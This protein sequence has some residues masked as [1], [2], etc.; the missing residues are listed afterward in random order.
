MSF[1]DNTNRS[2]AFME[3]LVDCNM[4]S[5]QLVFPFLREGESLAMLPIGNKPKS[6]YLRFLIYKTI[7]QF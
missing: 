4:N 5:Q 6:P 7:V 2:S 3:G 1:Q